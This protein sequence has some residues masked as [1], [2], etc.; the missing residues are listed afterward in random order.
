MRRRNLPLKNSNRLLLAL[1]PLVPVALLSLAVDN[2]DTVS[3]DV[4]LRLSGIRPLATVPDR[5]MPVSGITQPIPAEDTALEDDEDHSDK[6]ERAVAELD[7]ADLRACLNELR[8]EELGGHLGRLLVRRWAAAD[9]TAAANWAERLIDANARVELGAAVALV[10]SEREVVAALAWAQHLV[11]GEMRDRVIA[12]LG[13]EIARTEPVASLLLAAN[14]PA[15]EARDGLVLHS[16]AQ[17]ANCDPD[18]AQ[19]WGLQ[20]PSGRLREQALA[21]IAVALANRAAEH[22]ARFA[23]EFIRPG[24]D[25]DR[26]VVGVVQRWAQADDASA[27]AWVNRFSR[28]PLQ[29]A[30]RDVLADVSRDRAA[31]P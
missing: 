6:L 30:A 4:S 12:D 21:T 31:H 5:S 18:N 9:P 19:Q 14:L 27:T 1:L 8:P 20:L 7:L 26:A 29:D 28:S 24:A 23:V 2:R 25:L 22:G 11:A 10:W 3:Q 17:W 15:S 16:L 13:F